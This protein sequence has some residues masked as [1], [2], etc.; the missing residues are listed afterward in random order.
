MHVYE[1]SKMSYEWLYDSFLENGLPE[2]RRLEIFA[3]S[4]R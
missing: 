2:R 1:C 3:V 4:T